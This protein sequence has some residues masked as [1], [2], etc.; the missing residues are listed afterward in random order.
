MQRIPFHVVRDD[1]GNVKIEAKAVNKRFSPE[2]ISSQAR[3]GRRRRRRQVDRAFVH[4]LPPKN[5]QEEPDR[6][7]LLRVRAVLSSAAFFRLAS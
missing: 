4:A 3:V 5:N 2:E 7:R 6:R 1:G